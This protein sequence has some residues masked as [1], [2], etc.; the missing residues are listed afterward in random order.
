MGLIKGDNMGATIA[1]NVLLTITVVV[2]S[3]LAVML[4]G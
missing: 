4:I 2:W 1:T 3:S